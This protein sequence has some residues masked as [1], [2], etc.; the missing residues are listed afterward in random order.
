MRSL[1]CML[2]PT[3]TC[4][5]HNLVMATHST[6]LAVVGV[7]NGVVTTRAGGVCGTGVRRVL[8]TPLGQPAQVP[9][10]V[11]TTPSVI[12]KVLLKAVTKEAKKKEKIFTL[13]HIYTEKISS[14]DE[15]KKIIKQQLS[16]DIIDWEEFDVG[17]I[18]INRKQGEKVISIRS[19]ADIAEVWKEIRAQGDKMQL[20]CDGLEVGHSGVQSSK[21]RK[22][23]NV[24]DGDSEDDRP[25]KKSAR[26]EREEK[27]KQALDTLN[28]KHGSEYS[29]MQYRIWS[30]MY[31]NGMHTD[32]ENPPNNSM[33]KRAGSS[34]PSTKK[35]QSDST[36]PEMAQALTQAASQVSSAIV[37]AFSPKSN[38][39]STSSGIS[40]AKVIENRSRCYKQLGDLH[41]LRSQGLL[42]E[43]DYVRE[44][45]AITGLLKKLV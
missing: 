33:F 34:T 2:H 17:Y 44:K 3:L 24:D 37:A 36:S 10:H 8:I 21:K 18:N 26:E 13:R 25:K 20:W 38:T 14:C 30:E 22:R 40:P 7:N 19:K 6:P 5:A 23:A 32:L 12:N 45:D 11:Q 35:K 28:K 39:L 42:S 41:S 31:A 43:E 4:S 15:L 27:L 16:N 1:S 9:T 29:Q